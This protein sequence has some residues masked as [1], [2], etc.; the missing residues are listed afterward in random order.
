M[1]FF[2]LFFP[3]IFIP[4]LAKLNSYFCR[5]FFK[6]HVTFRT[7]LWVIILP[8]L[9]SKLLSLSILNFSFMHP[10]SD[11]TILSITQIA[12]WASCFIICL[13]DKDGQ[14][15]GWLRSMV[16]FIVIAIFA[17]ATYHT[18]TKIVK[19]N[20]ASPEPIEWRSH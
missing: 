4:L 13:K 10:L 16:V 9:L 12:I 8:V 20:N 17:S 14:R 1:L 19:K 3:Y 5:L 6:Y 2:Y 18:V 15:L 7:A 11:K